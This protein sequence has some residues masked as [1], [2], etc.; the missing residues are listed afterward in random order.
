M[1]NIVWHTKLRIFLDLT[2]DDLGHSEFPDLW[3]TVYRTDRLYAARGVPVAERD[4]QC[5]GV[6]QEAGVEAWLHLRLRAGRREAVHEKAEDE[7]RHNVPMSDEHKAYQE[8]ILRVAQEDGFRADS[9]VRTRVGRSWIQT[10][11]LVEGDGGRR[12]GWEVQLSSAGMHGPRSV[13]A[14]AARAEKNGITPA[15]HTDRSDYARRNDTHWTRSNN[16]P[17]YVIAKN[18]DLRVVSG[19][20]ALDFWHCDIHAVYPCPNGVRR[21]GRF[22]A[23]PKPRDVLFD[24]LVRRTAAGT[25][26]PVQFRVG[27]TTHRFWVTDADRDRLEDLRSDDTQLPPAQEPNPP[28]RASRNRPTCKPSLPTADTPAP[29]P[30]LPDAQIPAQPAPVEEQTASVQPAAA[31]RPTLHS[32]GLP[33]EL[34]ELQQTA[35]DAS[36]QLEQL[37]DHQERDRQ[38]RV[39]RAAAVTVQA[40]VTQYARSKG[41]NRYEVEKQ[42]R[43]VVRHPRTQ[44]GTP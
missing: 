25:I 9:E 28:A 44:Q 36:A 41:L 31:T 33:T 12:I 20:R 24:D 43:Q 22:H 26:V 10:D 3:E 32:S 16:L 30:T 39:W 7:D 35:D 15:W 13:R 21:C 27:A 6:C 18:G 40:A 17:A 2:R 42:L 8:R 11:T 29:G 23:T 5:G 14:R 38:R 1:A 34:V 37:T 19:F 4:L